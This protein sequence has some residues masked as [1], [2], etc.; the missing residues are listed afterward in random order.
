[1]CLLRAEPKHTGSALFLYCWLSARPSPL[2]R[3]R[4]RMRRLSGSWRTT[5]EW[6]YVKALDMDNYKA[7]LAREL[8]GLAFIRVPSQPEGP[9][10]RLDK[11]HTDKGATLAWFELKAGG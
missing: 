11:A 3:S 4:R 7:L 5:I 1:M 2:L 9:Y 8:C 10:Y 6:E